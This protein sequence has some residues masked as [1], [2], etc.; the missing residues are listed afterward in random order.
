[1]THTAIFFPDSTIF[2]GL[3]Q[4]AIV[5]AAGMRRITQNGKGAYLI[6]STGWSYHHKL[7]EFD[8]KNIVVD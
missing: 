8:R 7:L 6:G 4:P 2:L 1:L 5:K 3:C